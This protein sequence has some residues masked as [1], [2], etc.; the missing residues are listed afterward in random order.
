M[1]R[2]KQNTIACES[3]EVSLSPKS[4]LI[5]CFAFILLKHRMTSI[6]RLLAVSPFLKCV[7]NTFL[8]D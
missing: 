3:A 7:N 2:L 6:L 1:Q 4:S 8:T 5:P